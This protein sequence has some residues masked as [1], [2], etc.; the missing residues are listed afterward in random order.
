MRFT[1]ASLQG[2]VLMFGLHGEGLLRRTSWSRGWFHWL[3]WFSEPAGGTRLITQPAVWP[4]ADPPLQGR[5]QISGCSVCVWLFN[6]I[7]D[8]QIISFVLI[9]TI[10]LKIDIN[11]HW[12]L[13][14]RPINSLIIWPLKGSKVIISELPHLQAELCFQPPPHPP[15]PQSPH[16]QEALL[17][18]G[19]TT[20][21]S[22]PGTSGVPGTEERFCS[23]SASVWTSRWSRSRRPSPP[24]TRACGN[25]P[26]PAGWDD[27][28]ESPRNIW[29]TSPIWG[30]WTFSCTL[31]GF[32]W[33]PWRFLFL[34]LDQG[35]AQ[36]NVMK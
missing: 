11:K 24:R 31:Y 16:P 35:T 17:V 30:P 20:S 2:A 18:R 9:W 8:G 27:T 29:K 32:S 1:A 25:A 21:A 10:D 4:W 33:S 26:S 7:T 28:S 19:W 22:P 14:D 13:S 5:S 23:C 12:W 15:P 6:R 36:K 3:D 34:C